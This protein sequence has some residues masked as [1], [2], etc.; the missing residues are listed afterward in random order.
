[1]VNTKHNLW[2]YMDRFLSGFLN[3]EMLVSV[4]SMLTLHTGN[5]TRASMSVVQG[6]WDL[7]GLPFLAILT[8]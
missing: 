7:I 8:F 1:M 2:V 3:A 5:L 4:G 6:E